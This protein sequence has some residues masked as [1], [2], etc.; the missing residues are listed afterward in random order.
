[1]NHGNRRAWKIACTHRVRESIRSSF[2]CEIRNVSLRRVLHSVL[3]RVL[4]RWSPRFFIETGLPAFVERSVETRITLTA[5]VSNGEV[6]HALY[7]ANALQNRLGAVDF[8]YDRCY[9]PRFDS[10]EA[11]LTR[12]SHL[13]NFE[14][15][16]N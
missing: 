10:S 9:R 5:K 16:R 11:S 13:E 12:M 15:Y 7:S 8:T 6:S 4:L 14:K 1:M 2:V 3:S